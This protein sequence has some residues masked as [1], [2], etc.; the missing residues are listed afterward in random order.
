MDNSL[1]SSQVT[2][3]YFD[4]LSVADEFFSHILNLETVMDAGWAKVYRTSQAAFVGAVQKGKGSLEDTG[5]HGVMVSLTTD[6]A[7]SAREKL[8]KRTPVGELKEFA[9]IGLR[10]FF[11]EGPEGYVFEVQQFLNDKEKA[12]F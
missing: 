10:S 3:L 6:D 4:D 5:A 12:I 9:D 1:F 11:V 2:F 7:A 8:L